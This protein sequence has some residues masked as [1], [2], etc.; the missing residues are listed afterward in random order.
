MSTLAGDFWVCGTCR[1]IN[2]A[3]A[4]QCYNCR[5]PRDV[6]EVD[7][8]TIDAATPP[9]ASEAALPEFRSSRGI[10]LLASILILAVVGVQIVY[11][12][13]W[14]TVYLDGTD[15]TADA[16]R[17][18]ETIGVVVLGIGA[19]ALI[20]WALWLSRAVTSMPAL[21][22]GYPST[23]GLAAFLENFVPI[24]NLVLIPP[25]VR[26]V[27]VRL[28]ASAARSGTLI[29]AAW[30]GLVAGFLVPRIAWFVEHAGGT[31]SPS[32]AQSQLMLQVIGTGLVLAS[33]TVLVALVW[34]I[35]ARIQRRRAAQTGDATAT[36]GSPAVAAQ[37]TRPTVTSTNGL[38]V[39]ATRSAF[40]A[41]GTSAATV[42]SSAT[43]GNGLGSIGS[44]LSPEA[45]PAAAAVAAAGALAASR[46][47]STPA[48]AVGATVAG[49]DAARDAWPD[50]APPDVAPDETIT[51]APTAAAQALDADEPDGIEPVAEPV[52]EAVAEPQ[53]AP[54][55][56]T[57]P[58]P[59]AAVDPPES[60]AARPP[61]LS[62]TIGSHGMMTAELDGDTEHV[63][64]DDLTA[65][66]SALANV[67]GT[68]SISV[69]TDDSMAG[70][71]ARR[72]QRIL[73]DVGVQVATD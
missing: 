28:E 45:V 10:A 60:A 56:A 12:L 73:E 66:G 50:T 63:I 25:I 37:A 48:A 33:A 20:G 36:P 61:H 3:G 52:T 42:L 46:Q 17:F 49:A 2:N 22:L 23:S 72:A 6:A 62:I 70:L 21:G 4:D 40:A 19:L 24:L 57:V 67:G 7:P 44:E 16:Q 58:Q 15:P 64:L 27:V 53:A 32:A 43:N 18:V 41:G 11:T 5:A 59:V 30:I 69:R 14:S 1:S 55:P 39:V 34:W 51:G 9:A 38:D 71:V 31:V 35:E 13:V 26:D 47:R 8:A 29:Y 54:E 65:Y 68:A